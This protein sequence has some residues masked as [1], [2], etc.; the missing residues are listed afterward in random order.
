MVSTPKTLEFYFDFGSPNAYL[1]FRALPLLLARAG[2]NL[3]MKPALIGAIF[4]AT[5]NRSPIEAF[6]P[7]K[8]KLDYERLEMRRFVT[9]HAIPFKFNPH[10]PINTLKLMRGY[11]AA[12]ELGSD[13]AYT[14]A[15]WAGMW[16]EG[17]AMGDAEVF[18][19]RLAAAGL[20]ARAILERSEAPETKA[21]LTS[22]TEESVARGVFGL[23]TMF[24]GAEM[25]FGK[26]RLGQIEEE[27]KRV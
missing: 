21:A 8:G 16:E 14:E 11:I 2:A 13:H 18:A 15:C 17:A 6:A 9:K 7:V 20:D 26:E 24:V 27:L 4:K 19:G 12:R 22:A 25:Y 1:A 10:F 23:P 3:A 5:G